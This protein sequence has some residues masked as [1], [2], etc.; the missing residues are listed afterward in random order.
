MHVFF[1]FF[2]HSSHFL[3][4]I[5]PAQGDI[6][7]SVGSDIVNVEANFADGKVVYADI[8]FEYI[9]EGP[10]YFKSMIM[11]LAHPFILLSI[12]YRACRFSVVQ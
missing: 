11:R 4:L 6:G 9:C 1:L 2:L 8:Q 3:Q 5:L 12:F 10:C 7:P